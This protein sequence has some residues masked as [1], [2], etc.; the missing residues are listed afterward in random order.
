MDDLEQLSDE[1]K[2]AW[3][4]GFALAHPKE[5]ARSILEDWYGDRPGVRVAVADPLSKEA[6]YAELERLDSEECQD[7]MVM[8]WRCGLFAKCAG[9]WCRCSLAC[10][11]GRSL[12]RQ[13][14]AIRK[15]NP[16]TTS[17][18]SETPTRTPNAE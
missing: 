16:T 4:R 3:Q 9:G 7:A 1:A 15:S 17:A 8:G 14:A 5:G 12:S 2:R 6:L 11:R 13:R 10:P 18:P